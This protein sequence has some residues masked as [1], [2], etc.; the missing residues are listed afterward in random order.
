MGNTDNSR[1]FSKL[2]QT[3]KQ[4]DATYS[5][6]KLTV[7]LQ[8]RINALLETIVGLSHV[9]LTMML[10]LAVLITGGEGNQHGPGTAGDIPLHCDTSNT[11]E[12]L[13][14]LKRYGVTAVTVIVDLSGDELTIRNYKGCPLLLQ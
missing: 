3:A 5:L 8:K 7:E 9:P 10:R 1:I 13:A 4:D 6:V 11:D 2:L 14:V 12:E